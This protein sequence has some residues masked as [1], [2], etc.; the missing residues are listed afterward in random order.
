M[1]EEGKQTVENLVK[2]PI[3]EA[4]LPIQKTKGDSVLGRKAQ[5]VR[6]DRKV[7]N[8]GDK[9]AYGFNCALLGDVFACQFDPSFSPVSHFEGR[10]I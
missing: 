5:S 3:N 8:E 6:V 2:I 10:L 4:F 9:L 1:K 7:D